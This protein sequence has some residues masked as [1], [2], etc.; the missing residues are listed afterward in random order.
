MQTKRKIGLTK[1]LNSR[2]GTEILDWVMW[3]VDHTTH[4]TKVSTPSR[5]IVTETKLMLRN[6]EVE[7]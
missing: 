6:V 5:D 3:R 2:V 4:M 1:R 7:G